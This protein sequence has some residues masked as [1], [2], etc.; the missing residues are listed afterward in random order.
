MDEDMVI[1]ALI[2]NA[3]ALLV[4][5][6]QTYLTRHSL[7]TAKVSI[8]ENRK[9]RCKWQ[10]KMHLARKIKMH[11][12]VSLKNGLLLLSLLNSKRFPT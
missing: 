6:Y 10:V 8:D 2:L 7:N 5:A 3:I 4:V 11:L 12:S 9:T 1:F